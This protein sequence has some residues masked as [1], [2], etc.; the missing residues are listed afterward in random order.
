MA[1]ANPIYQEII[2]RELTLGL[3]EDILHVQASYVSHDGSLNTTKLL[4]D[5]TQ[6]YRKHA[7]PWLRQAPYREA[8]P[9]LLLMA[10]LQKV[11]NGG[12]QI[13]R[14]YAL[15][16]KKVDLFIQWKE[17]NI[18]MEIKIKR[19]PQTLLRGLDQTSQYMDISGAQE[20][21]LVVFDRDLKKSWEE[22]ISNEVHSYGTKKIH[23][24]TM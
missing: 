13:T 4:K 1:I 8:G 9:H 18:V 14:E 16:S 19:G 2:P 15:G 11:V 17:Q 5:F 23:V 12:G 7:T 20:G 24:W 3:Q 6:F 10:F 22:R 21:H